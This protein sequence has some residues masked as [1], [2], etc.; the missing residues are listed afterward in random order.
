MQALGN[1]DAGGA[2][3]VNIFT[4]LSLEASAE[5]RI[6]SI[7]VHVGAQVFSEPTTPNGTLSN[8]TGG[9]GTINYVTGALTIQTAPVLAV[10]AVA[11]TFSYYPCLPV[12]G[13]R[14]QELYSTSTTNLIAFDT[15]YSYFY[16]GGWEIFPAGSTP[17]LWSGSDSQFFWTTNYWVDKSNFKVF[18]ATNFNTSTPDPIRYTNGQ[19]GTA[20]YDFAPIINAGGDTLINCLAMLPFRGRMC[21]FNTIEK[22][23]ATNIPVAYPN[24]IR[25]AAIGN[26][27]TVTSPIVTVTTP[28]QANAWKDDIRGK[29]GFLDIPT[30]EAITSVGFVRDNLVI[31]C[32]RS[33]WQLRY[34]GRSIAP[35]QIEKVNSELGAAST[36]SAVQFDTSLVGV[37]D[38]GIVECDSY[39]SRRIDVKIPDLVFYFSNENGGTIRV[40]GIRNFFQKLAFWIYPLFGTKAIYP[41]RRLVYNYENDSWAI[42]TDSLTSLG[43]FQPIDNKKWIDFAE[44]EP[45]NTWE[46]QNY[47]W[48]DRPA[49]FPAV[50]GGNQQGYVEIL[51]QQVSNDESLTITSIT[52]RDTMVTLVKVN[53]HNLENGQVIEISGI[54]PIS[55]FANLNYGIFSIIQDSSDPANVIQLWKYNPATGQFNTPQVDPSAGIYIGGGQIAIRDNFSI[56]SKKFNYMDNGQAFQLGYIDI[57]LA[58]T[59][60]GGISL[61]VYNDYDNNQTSNDPFE[62]STNDTFFNQV[63]PTNVNLGTDGGSKNWKRVICPTNA[64]FVTIEWTLSNLQMVGP[65]Q[66]S[67]VQIDAQTIWSR[68][69]G[70]LRLNG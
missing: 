23:F 64:N 48:F 33:T 29:G 70:R 11:I 44:L 21:V 39:Q 3:S 1:T 41:N 42:F 28:G 13:L 69:G 14:T 22:S 18:W 58:N 52:G 6:G 10:T 53:N 43:T 25:W 47:P 62:N 32:E 27:F 49:D 12:M 61:N 7:K 40:Q 5:L 67:E 56:T 19:S 17:T 51:D 9:T 54:L 66:E 50:V 55:S 2:I 45:G 37:G 31:Y 15:V 4:H 59:E 35:F 65:E 38:K 20:W 60:A 34:T 63:V 16:N 26:P 57:L 8:G 24:R 68:P 46:L 36:F 30:S